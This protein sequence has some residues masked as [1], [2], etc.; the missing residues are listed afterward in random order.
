MGETRDI[1]T[2]RSD[3]AAGFE[4][5]GSTDEEIVVS[6]FQDNFVVVLTVVLEGG[7]TAIKS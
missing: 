3:R 4:S 1:A 6:Q 5:L 2:H 7:N